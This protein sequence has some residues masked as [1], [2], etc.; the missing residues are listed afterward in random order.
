MRSMP[1]QPS[2]KRMRLFRLLARRYFG[3][4]ETDV[5]DSRATHDVDGSRN[6]GELDIIITL[7]KS[8]LVGAS[9]EN[10]GEA[11]TEIIPVALIL[12]DHKLSAVHDLNHDRAVIGRLRLC[13][14]RRGLGN[15]GL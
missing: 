7:H 1:A 6:L 15:K 11:R 13:I 2:D 3:S 12:I 5:I 8:D 4:N 9:L 10:I 14:W